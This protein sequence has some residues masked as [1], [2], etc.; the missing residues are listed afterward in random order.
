MA[1]SESLRRLCAEAIAC[2]M[3]RGQVRSARPVRLGARDWDLRTMATRRH[4]TEPFFL[5]RLKFLGDQHVSS[6]CCLRGP[7]QIRPVLALF[8]PGVIAQ[9][10]GA[11]MPLRSQLLP[12]PKDRPELFVRHLRQAL[13]VHFRQEPTIRWSDAGYC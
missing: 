1:L 7:R 12:S 6:P 5:N 3:V 4:P 8:R 2:R 9:L 10:V 11:L 13:E